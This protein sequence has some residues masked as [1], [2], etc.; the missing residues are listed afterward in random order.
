MSMHL[1]STPVQCTNCGTV[2]D[3][4]RVDHCPNC[5][6]LLRERRTPS[7]LAGVE[8]RYAGLRFLMSFLRFLGIATLL[9][10]GLLFAFG[11][12]G[13]DM[14][15]QAGILTL[16]GT[17]LAAVVLFAVASFFEVT[18]DMEENTRASFRVQQ[19]L[20]EHVQHPHHDAP[21]PAPASPGRQPG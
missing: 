14:T 3:D 1:F 11:I 9:V 16:L 13:D 4:P 19:M 18:L 17:V 15:V 7:R 21:A 10:G 5:N 8:K 6:A 12:G 2:V 20:L